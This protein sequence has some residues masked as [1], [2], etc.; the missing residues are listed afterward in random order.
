[1]LLVRAGREQ[2]E[3]RHRGQEYCGSFGDD[4]NGCVEQDARQDESTPIRREYTPH[5][6]G[7]QGL[8]IPFCGYRAPAC[9]YCY[10]P[11]RPCSYA[12]A[13]DSI[14]ILLG[15]GSLADVALGVFALL[16]REQTLT[17]TEAN[18]PEILIRK[19]GAWVYTTTSIMF[20]FHAAK[21]LMATA[22]TAFITALPVAAGSFTLAWS[23]ASWND[24]GSL[25][26]NFTFVYDSN[27]M[28]TSLVS[29]DVTTG[30]GT[31]DGFSGQSY[32]YNVPGLTSTVAPD[33]IT[34]DA[35]QFGGYPAN[36]LEM[37]DAN[38]YRIFLDWQ[39]TSPSLLWIGNVGGQYSSE[40]NPG[41]SIIRFINGSTGS[42]GTPI[43]EP[44]SLLLVGLG[45]AG[46]CLFRRRKATESCA[47]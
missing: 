29:A 45:L 2:V 16:D 27:G 28:P 38:G 3:F 8:L 7:N 19:R 46:L 4:R 40:N 20:P 1:L 37:T 26:G 35:T 10:F 17:S 5:R 23:G 9:E 21:L 12:T 34:F 43:P 11:P 22:L 42:P 14:L 15:C 44:A 47:R 6:G 32:V 39:G 33:A 36:E 30:D 31:S 25:A 13:L 18:G 41:D 24:G